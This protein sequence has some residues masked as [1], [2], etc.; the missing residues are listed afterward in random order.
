[1]RKV[2]IQVKPNNYMAAKNK[3]KSSRQAQQSRKY[4]ENK[5][6]GKLSIVIPVYNEEDGLQTIFREL[7]KSGAKL[8]I[9]L[10]SYFC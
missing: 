10:R 2:A 5:Y 8:E 3:K 7:Q 4:P 9:T 1:M 6:Q